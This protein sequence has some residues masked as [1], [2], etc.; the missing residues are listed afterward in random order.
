MDL[1]QGSWVNTSYWDWTWKNGRAF[2]KSGNFAK[3]GRVEDFTQ[4]YWKSQGILSVRK[5][6]KHELVTQ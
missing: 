1:G 2:K 3:T 6:G 4:K 5:N